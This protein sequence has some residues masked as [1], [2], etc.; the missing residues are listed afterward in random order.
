MARVDVNIS[1]ST[2]PNWMMI[3]IATAVCAS[4]GIAIYWFFFRTPQAVSGKHGNVVHAPQQIKGYGNR[5]WAV[6]DSHGN[7]HYQA[8]FNDKGQTTI[9]TQVIKES[10]MRE[11]YP[12]QMRNIQDCHCVTDQHCG[13]GAPIYMSPVNSVAPSASQWRDQA[14][15]AYDGYGCSP[16][17]GSDISHFDRYPN[18]KKINALTHPNGTITFFG[19]DVTCPSFPRGPPSK[20]SG[21]WRSYERT[22]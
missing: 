17:V 4:G 13:P 9:A 19:M 3:G 8:N 22:W 16:I 18:V 15:S 6:K 11:Y 5:C 7:Y 20:K 1:D 14:S 2:Q 12:E 10:D 21:E